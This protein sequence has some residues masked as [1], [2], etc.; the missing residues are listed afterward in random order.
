MSGCCRSGRHI[1]EPT[2]TTER[3]RNRQVSFLNMMTLSPEFVIGTD[4]ASAKTQCLQFISHAIACGW[5]SCRVCRAAAAYLIEVPAG[6]ARP[7]RHRV[8]PVPAPC[9][10]GHASMPSGL[11]AVE[12]RSAKPAPGFSIAA[13]APT[14]PAGRGQ[15]ATRRSSEMFSL[16]RTCRTHTAPPCVHPASN[17]CAGSLSGF[18]CG[19]RRTYR[20]GCRST[21]SPR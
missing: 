20:S 11:R 16:I 5:V 9:W 21:A 15:E 2:R 6:Q 10:T 12:Q 7:E 14:L 3:R 4:L 19:G 17:S 13:S 18:R 8:R 1:R